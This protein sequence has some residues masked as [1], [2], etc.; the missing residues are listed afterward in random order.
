MARDYLT[1]RRRPLPT[2]FLSPYIAV[3]I[4]RD[5]LI[6][7]AVLERYLNKRYSYKLVSLKRV[8]QT[9]KSH[10]A[11][12]EVKTDTNDQGDRQRVEA[13]KLRQ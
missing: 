6:I 2:F 7:M 9:K 8:H 11:V 13:E 12:R 1:T 5:V 3:L 4:P 10:G